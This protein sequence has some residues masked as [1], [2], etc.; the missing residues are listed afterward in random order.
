MSDKTPENP[1]DLARQAAQHLDSYRSAGVEWLPAAAP[2]PPPEKEPEA[3][4]ASEGKGRQPPPP[5]ARPEAA[6]AIVAPSPVQTALFTAAAAADRLP[7]DAEQRRHALTLLAQQVATCT[8]CPQ[9]ASTRTQTVFGV[10]P[11]DP[12]L[13]FVGEAP[14]ADEDRLGEPFVGVAGQLLTRIIVAMGLKREEVFICNILR[15][16]PPGN[17]TPLPDE[18]EHCREWLEKTLEMVRPRFICA[19]GNTPA[20]DLLGIVEPRIT[21]LRGRFFDYR[22]IPVMLTFHP[23][24]L[25]RNPAAK[26][27]VW[28]DMKTLLARMGRP[29]PGRD[30]TPPSG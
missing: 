12:E 4:R 2:T 13:C 14:G 25:L 26:K 5:V 8:R 24:Y 18:A 7:S 11:I 27:D 19:L 3:R 16:R 28:D 21:R 6:P 10:G 15:C 20:R 23:S 22:G 9:L 29:I 1:P 30:V 17:R